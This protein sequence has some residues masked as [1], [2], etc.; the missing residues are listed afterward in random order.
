MGISLGG[1]WAP[2]SN[3]DM[4]IELRTR[5]VETCSVTFD[6]GNVQVL[7][8]N[9]TRSGSDIEIILSYGF[10]LVY[11]FISC[12]VLFFNGSRFWETFS[13]ENQRKKSSL[14]FRRPHAVIIKSEM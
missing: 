12:F 13:Q 3:S 11:L 14:T 8:N 10:I 5:L 9:E 2:F 1:E 4:V 6:D 7:N